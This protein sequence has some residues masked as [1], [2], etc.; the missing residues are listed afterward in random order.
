MTTLTKEVL[1]AASEEDFELV[2]QARRGDTRAFDALMKKYKERAVRAVYAVVGNYEDAKD[3][4]QEAFVKAYRSLGQFQS[5][6]QFFT[7]FYRILMNTAKDFL[8]RKALRQF[9]NFSDQEEGKPDFLQSVPD[10][11]VAADD[12]LLGTELGSKMSEIVSSLPM[13]QR[14][15]FTLRFFEGLSLLE[16][17]MITRLSEGGVK[18]TLHI[19]VQKF[20]TAIQPY[21]AEGR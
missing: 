12:S 1:D 16:I 14:W 6:A 13:Q 15:V 5:R 2:L 9:L 18:A 19:A 21:L 10:R 4:A 3:I 7:W 11:A 8:R 20:K 17:S